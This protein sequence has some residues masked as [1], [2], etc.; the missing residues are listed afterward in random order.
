MRFRKFLTHTFILVYP[1]SN[2]IYQN[3]IK[4]ISF[5]H[6]FCSKTCYNEYINNQNV[7]TGPKCS[8]C[9]ST[10]LLINKVTEKKDGAFYPQATSTYRCTNEPC[11][12]QIDKETAK[13][14]KMRDD[15]RIEN[16][17]RAEKKVQEKEA[18]RKIALAATTN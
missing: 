16:E 14:V 5:E 4:Y 12:E 11:Q 13:R 7:S 9:G 17:K 8:Q 18:V 2:T 15:K 6:P 3:T 10:L 1:F